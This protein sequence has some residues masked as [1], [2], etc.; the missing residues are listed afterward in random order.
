MKYNWVAKHF[1]KFNKAK[2]YKS[3][4]DYKRRPK[5]K[6]KYDKKSEE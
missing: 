6:R 4:K 3:K 2:V 1:R 5:H